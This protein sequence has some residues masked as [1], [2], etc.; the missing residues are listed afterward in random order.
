MPRPST[1][2]KALSYKER[3]VIEA[4][5]KK[6]TKVSAIAKMLDRHRATIYRELKFQC[7]NPNEYKNY[8]ADL[9][10]QKIGERE[11]KTD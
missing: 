5:I 2:Y 10:Q 3:L 1:N 6:G 11:K 4:E 9:G 7:N 8:N